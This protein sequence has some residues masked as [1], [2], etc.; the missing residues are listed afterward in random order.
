M[1]ERLDD[2]R[3]YLLL[4]SVISFLTFSIY[5]ESFYY[6][7]PS[8]DDHTYFY[9]LN[10][11]LKNGL[12]IP[13]L[14]SV[15]SDF[16]NANW[17]P[18]TILSLT[19]D[20]FAG[21]GH[22]EYFH[23][24]NSLI[25]IFNAIIVYAII[26]YISNKKI[27]IITAIFFTVHPLNV[28]TVIWISERKGL[29]STFFALLSIY[30]YLVFSKKKNNINKIYSVLFFSLSLMSKPTTAS[31]PFVLILFDLLILNSSRITNNLIIESIKN[32]AP[33]F[34]V[35][36]VIISISYIAQS[37]NEALRDF[38][39]ISIYDRA[40]YS[41]YN[42]FSYISK[43]FLPINLALYYPQPN[44][45]T[46]LILLYFVI[47]NA[48]LFIL[49]KYIHKY[50]VIA[51]GLLFFLI[52]IIPMSG[53]FQTGSH[54]IALRYTYLP[55]IGFYF[56]AAYYLTKIK[57]K[58][59][60]YFM[61]VIVFVTLSVTAYFQTKVWS[62]KIS[63]WK[64]TVENTNKNYY[65][66]LIYSMIL[67]EDDQVIKGVK[68]FYDNMG[69]DNKFFEIDAI[70]RISTLLIE[71]SHF[72]EAKLILER[73]IELGIK[74]AKVY[75]ELAIVEYF[76]S[77]N[78]DAALIYMKAVFE[79]IPDDIRTARYY[80]K[81]LQLEGDKENALFVLNQTQALNPDNMNIKSDIELLD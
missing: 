14:V 45:N 58:N 55:A 19:I 81:M 13:V 31:I 38:S 76:F 51:F 18:V 61:L 53:V 71:K 10:D 64:N 15:F 20:Y 7:D 62:N 8:Y 46:Y 4:F 3:L 66:G 21:G 17:H 30:Q 72:A 67:I 22:L 80:A 73:A 52:Q 35:V 78:K 1:L 39:R 57:T 5:Y 75:R 43:I 41:L 48:W 32:K 79:S 12:D 16:V 59:L 54:S 56:F 6:G 36:I 63:L 23:F 42:I 26:A 24:V 34:I 47:S 50:K 68:Y 33:Y 74:H 65:S 44:L 40:A 9:Y 25:H 29:L 49:F 77:G 70:F 27:A 37:E 2:K 28:E 60:K 69:L 11:L